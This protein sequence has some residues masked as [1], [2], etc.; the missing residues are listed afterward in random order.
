MSY[1]DDVGEQATDLV[2]S[3]ITTPGSTKRI[4]DW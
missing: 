1:V 4:A 3:P 2:A